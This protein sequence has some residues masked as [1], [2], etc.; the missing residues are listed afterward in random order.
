[1]NFFRAT[2]ILFL[3]TLSI[4][5]FAQ[6]GNDSYKAGK[7]DTIPMPAYDVNGELMLYSSLPKVTISSAAMSE[8]ERARFKRLKYNVMKVMPYAKFARDR[9]RTLQRD[10][11]VTDDNRKQRKLVKE[12][13]QQI[14]DM[15]NREV[16]KLSINQG[17]ILI[18][19]IDRETGN[20]SYNLV[21]EL[22]GGLTAF[23]YQSIARVVGHDLK[24]QYDP[25]TER[26][27]ESII[28][29]SPYRYN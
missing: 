7:N 1:M 14:K 18:K 28:Q 4:H 11:A 21:K 6:Q 15:F 3:F 19:L 13:D 27:I 24:E 16:K 22:K 9:Y 23:F 17:E 20:S 12:C 29:A 10:L 8:A 25:V 2:A 26:D 5:S